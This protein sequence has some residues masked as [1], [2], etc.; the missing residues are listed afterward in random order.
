MPPRLSL[1]WAQ[2][3]IKMRRYGELMV[4]RCSLLLILALLLAA[5]AAPPS[6]P[7]PV[8]A[9]P[10][11]L[12][13]TATRVPTVTPAPA[14]TPTPTPQALRFWVAA[15]GPELA[16]LEA[17]A[18]DFARE[19]GAP[20][21]V[22]ARPPD[23]LR[24]SL[25]TAAL[26]GDPLPDLLW[27]DQEALAGLIVDGRLQPVP[28]AL[29]APD[30]LPAL[31][32][33]AT[34]D[35]QLWGLPATAHGALLLLYNRDLVTAAP[36]A[37]SDELIVQSRAAASPL[38]AGLVM[39][40]D[41]ARWALP[42]LYAFGGAPTSPDGQ[43]ITLDTPA[44]TSTLTLLRELYR[45]AP[46]NGDGYTRGQRLLAQGYAAFAID[47]DWTLER[48]R[49]LS[50]TLD[51]GIAPLPVVPATGRAATPPLGGS[52]LMLSADLAGEPLEHGLAFAAALSAPEAQAALARA[53]GGLPASAGGLALL[54]LAAD[55]ALAASAARAANAPGLPP[56]LA[57][58][59]ALY[60]IAVWL[61]GLHR[62]SL[63]PPSAPA[64]MQ[65]EAEACLRRG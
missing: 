63:D 46:T 4:K 61:P 54:D 52:Y 50:D 8:A 35:G 56:T 22:V 40:W 25:A 26:V 53:G 5:C 14:P 64:T 48:Y 27:G 59:C 57:A 60:G 38:V 39:A 3:T 37:T 55:P 7:E 45:A 29:A 19:R 23:G 2:G 62:G 30:T 42:W 33:A 43:T 6:P 24:L 51:L 17:L 13:P 11:P 65:R 21:E 16:A 34:A 32:T 41:E 36:P 18:A 44:M 28:A 47:G 49:T 20:L 15:E 9:A 31:L 58:R 12:P 10:T 1:R